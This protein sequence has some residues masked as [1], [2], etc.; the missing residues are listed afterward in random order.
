MH[1][2]S[3]SHYKDLNALVLLQHFQFKVLWPSHVN[4]ALVYKQVIHL[5]PL[6]HQ[7]ILVYLIP[8]ANRVGSITFIKILPDP[9]VLCIDGKLAR[10]HP[11]Q[12][13]NHIFKT[14]YRHYL[15]TDT[16]MSVH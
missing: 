5:T 12:H 13:G 10:T 3:T 6:G 15:N 14:L 11:R 7:Q 4:I 1:L 2:P 16:N 9:K 8:R